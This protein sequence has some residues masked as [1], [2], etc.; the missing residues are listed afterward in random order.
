MRSSSSST[1]LVRARVVVPVILL[2]IGWW[3]GLA[4]YVEADNQAQL[5]RSE[6]AVIDAKQHIELIARLTKERLAREAV[7]RKQTAEKVTASLVSQ[8]QA[9]KTPV[10]SPDLLQLVCNHAR[11][12][13]DPAKPDVLA[14]KQHC[15]KPLTYVPADLVSDSEVTL[16]R[17]AYEAYRAMKQA[18]ARS[19]V[20]FTPTSGYRSYETQ[21]GTFTDWYHSTGS[22]E[23][24]AEYA[25]LPGYSEHQLG[26]AVDFKADGCALEC[27]RSTSAYAWLQAHAHEYGFI[28][29]YPRSKEAVTGYG[30]EAWHWRYV[31]KDIATDMYTRKVATLEAYYDMPGGTP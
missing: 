10:L 11:E 1:P 27:F 30:A 17:P 13:D 4:T 16:A 14:N 25:A 31:G 5:R 21:I 20:S 2:A 19:S 23:R 28:E 18:A 9:G 3:Y 6:Q 8:I 15:I 26:L 12:H 7:E 22:A 24:A 29:R